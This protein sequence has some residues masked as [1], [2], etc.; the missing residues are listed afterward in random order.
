M[1]LKTKEIEIPENDP[2]HNNK[3]RREENAKILTEFICS[4]D[5]PIVLCID[6]EWGQ[7]KT[8][9]LRMW[10][11]YLQNQGF[12]TLCFSAWENDF[13]DD[14]LVSL[15]GEIS[16]AIKELSAHGDATKAQEYFDKAKN[17]SIGLLKRSVPVAVKL[18][19]A[20]AL[21]LDN[22]SE[23]AI[24]SLTESIAKEQIEK[25]EKSK[26]TL[27]EFKEAL[28]TFA[29]SLYENNQEASEAE[30]KLENKP[31]VFIIDE[32]DRCRPTFAIELLEKTKHFFNVKNI[33]FVIAADKKQLGHSI[34]AV[35]GQDLDVNGY[36]RR[37]IDF[38]YLLALQEPQK[39]MEFLFYKFGFGEYFRYKDSYLGG[40]E[41]QD[42][43]GF[44]KILSSIFGFT[45]RDQ[46]HCCSLLSLAI[47]SSH[48]KK[49]RI[50]KYNQKWTSCLC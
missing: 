1:L 36:L 38:D 33:V 32:L 27:A 11:Q 35:Y 48:P 43:I 19:T 28:E 29:N 44:L 46:E 18:A 17:L 22:L 8:T 39:Y 20:G 14:A 12:A 5:Q 3:L 45:L 13:S 40:R 10:K 30:T 41:G 16:S 25:Y 23:Q 15:I 7:G 4:F 2:F 49:T 21:D 26:K 50:P 31:V 6:A 42:I 9:F 37:F 47:K 24:A 34:R